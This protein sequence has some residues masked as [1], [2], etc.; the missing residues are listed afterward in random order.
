MKINI[1]ADI[2]PLM[3]ICEKAT[4]SSIINFIVYFVMKIQNASNTILIQ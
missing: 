2:I 3:I 1:V 4:V